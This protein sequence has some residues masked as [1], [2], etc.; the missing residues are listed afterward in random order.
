MAANPVS[1]FPRSFRRWS[2]IAVTPDHDFNLD[3]GTYGLTV[4]PGGFTSYQLL[5]LMSDG[6]TYAAVTPVMQADG[7][8]VLDLPAGQYSFVVVG[9]TALTGEIAK[10]HTG[11]AR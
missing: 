8:T 9:A 4:A 1:N 7:Y 3:A 6:A 10:I 11:R 2:A 5:K